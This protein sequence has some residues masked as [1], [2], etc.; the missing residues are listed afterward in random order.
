MLHVF[1]HIA[2]LQALCTLFFSNFNIRQQKFKTRRPHKNNTNIHI[3]HSEGHR[4]LD[5]DEGQRLLLHS[6]AQ[7]SL[8]LRVCGIDVCVSSFVWASCLEVFTQGFC[9][10]ARPSFLITP[11][12]PLPHHNLGTTLFLCVGMRT[13]TE[14]TA[15]C[16][17]ALAFSLL[18]LFTNKE[19]WLS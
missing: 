3:I 13:H 7:R 16:S 5:N 11:L 9:P 19:P 1:D 17:L 10:C 4:S 6:V 12:L 18:C 8:P 15:A 14:H 2:V